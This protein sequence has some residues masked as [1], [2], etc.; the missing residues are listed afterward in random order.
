MRAALL[1]LVL[2]FGLLSQ[3]PVVQEQEPP[4]E[5]LSTA[6]K[7]TYVLNPLQAGKEIKIGSFYLKKGSFRAAARRFEEATKWDPNSA[8]GFLKL[9]EAQKKLGNE[10]AAQE[11]WKKFLE[12]HPDGKE[13]ASVRK[14]LAKLKP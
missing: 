8:E 10:K 2:T 12:L 3:Q 6:E 9:G 14:K 7:Q 1:T 11:A 13:A 5:D 4:E